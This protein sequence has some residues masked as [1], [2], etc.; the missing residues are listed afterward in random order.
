MSEHQNLLKSGKYTATITQSYEDEQNEFNFLKLCFT[1]DRGEY[2]YR[3]VIEEFPL[4]DFG[5]KGR[6]KPLF[7]DVGYIIVKDKD[8]PIFFDQFKALRFEITIDRAISKNVVKNRV[9][10]LTLPL[11]K[12][13]YNVMK[14]KSDD[15]YY[16]KSSVK[17]LPIKEEVIER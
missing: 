15:H 4:N 10:E 13:D 5:I 1:I 9:I 6:L 3:N 7:D 8:N 14:E 16:E 11:K 2:S 12:A 17:K